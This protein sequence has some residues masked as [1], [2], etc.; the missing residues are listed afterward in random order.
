MTDADR[1]SFGELLYALA[2]TMRT[3]L[4]D[5]MLLGYWLGLQDMDIGT[6]TMACATAIRLSKYMPTPAVLRGYAPEVKRPILALAPFM[7]D[8]KPPVERPRPQ[9]M[10]RAV[11]GKRNMAETRLSAAIARRNELEMGPERSAANHEVSRSRAEYEHWAGY[12][13]YYRQ[14]CGGER[15]DDV[16]PAPVAV[17]DPRL[18]RE[19]DDGVLPF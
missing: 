7:G 1:P 10:L 2:A 4:D 3:A 12:V 9:S 8:R 6:L 18:P 19:D 16:K 15:D 14:I 5:A 17:H 11:E 13:G